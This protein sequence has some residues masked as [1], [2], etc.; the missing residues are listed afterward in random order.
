MLISILLIGVA[1][2]LP[3]S[4]TFSLL[5]L[6]PPYP[7]YR[8]VLT[9]VFLIQC[10]MNLNTSLYS[11]AIGSRPDHKGMT[12]EFGIS[13]QAARCGAMIFLVT[14]AFGCELWAPWS[15]EFGR[16]PVLQISLFFVNVWQLP[17]ALAPNFASVM[18]G[19]ALGGLS[20]AGGSVTLGLIADMFEPE[21]HQWA[22]NFVVLSS[23]GGS[24]V[25]PVIGG[26]CEQWL[27]W[28]WCIWLQLIAGGAVQ[29]L[30]LFT[31]PESRTTTMMTA[32]AK[33]RR[34]AG[35]DIYGPD[36]VMPWSQRLT[37]K[38]IVTTWT[39]PFVSAYLPA[40]YPTDSP[41]KT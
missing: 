10:S 11:N 2:V 23:V 33:R 25:G 38:D 37:V 39:R 30:H 29:L 19:R 34:K 17:V 9:V 18:V 7:T 6:T 28:Q 26:F 32:I 14:Y 15:E 5:P 20:S 21:D 35:E 8:W 24:A 27:K 16:K 13:A 1:W 40:F 22:V 4:H 3:C 31:V 36:E 12:E 41:V